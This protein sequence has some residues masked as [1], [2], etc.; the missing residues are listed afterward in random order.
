M[1]R[2]RTASPRTTIGMA[3]VFWLM[4]GFFATA[5]VDLPYQKPPKEILGLADATPPPQAMIDGQ[6]KYMALLTQPRFI[7]LEE[8]AQP[9]LKLAGLRINPR[10]HDRSRSRYTTGLA[11]QEVESGKAIPLT[12]LPEKLHLEYPRFSPGSAYFSF[13]QVRPEGMELWVIELASGRASRVTPP[14]LT[15]AIGF[16]YI[17]GPDE[18]SVICRTRPTTALFP[19]TTEL[20]AG[21]AIQEATGTKAAA[22]TYQ[23]LLRNKND[24]RKLEFYGTCAVTRYALD[25]AAAPWLPARLYRE[26]ELSPDGEYLLTTEVHPPYSYQFPGD[27]FP[28]AVRIY[29]RGGRMVKEMCDKP[30]QDKIPTAFD[31][32]EDGRRD[33]SWRD[34]QP[35]TLYW[36]EAADGG[37]PARE[38]M[39]RDRV[40]QLESPFAGE[41]RLVCA[42]KNRCRGIAWGSSAVA[43]VYD[44][45]WKT[46][47]MKIYRID[48]STTTS[49]PAILFDFSRED[50]YHQP[51]YFILKSDARGRD[52]LLSNRDGTKLYLDGEGYS[53]EGNRPF[54]DE[55]D[56]KTGRTKR[57]WQADGLKTYEDIIRVLDPDAG[58]LLTRIQAP[59]EYP[60]YYLR[61]IGSAAG[62][63]AV[64]AFPNPYQSF[65][66]VTKRQIHYKREDGL[67]LS[68]TLYLPPGYDAQKDGRLPMLMEAYPTEFKDKDAAGQVDDSPYRFVSFSWASPV[69]WA[70][71]GYAVLQD[72]KFPIVGQGQVEPNDTYIEQLVMDARAA[73]GAVDTLGVVDPKRVGV[74]GHSYG[75][76]MVANL[77]A[78]SDLF[79][80]G[81]ARSGAYNRSLTPFGF[82]AEERNYWQAQ[83]VYQKMSP[84]N[85]ADKIK[86]PLLLIHGDADNNPGT[87]TLQSERLFLA[88][89]GLG[90]TARLVL[91]PYESH[92]YAA[93]E[94]ILHMLW[95][96]DTWL[97]KY[98]KGPSGK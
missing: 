79:A 96:M 18:K 82:Q 81:I 11:I 64:T 67:D 84:F 54:L 24:E 62:P 98:V 3:L 66:S 78:H 85:Y 69:F 36:L 95:E 83:S 89:K 40:Y 65:A 49:E 29:D 94:N 30:L 52:R 13:I 73:I 55:F 63:K 10:T 86:A 20:P 5:Q 46:R 14:I 76:F 48:P 87:F 27:H 25:G 32:V 51:G 93:R 4:A 2:M 60:N 33:F 43:I 6:A 61:Q 21:P 28:Y 58:R 92:G 15:A 9:E 44:F 50:L 41:P 68:A 70:V 77:L 72:A 53:P 38:S 56:L 12:G 42:T 88:I 71:R 22:W 19:E 39:I 37:D 34:D 45:W 57:L 74:M 91:L 35:A 75:A 8:L 1:A 59:S 16:P 26:L 7:S 90:G 80:A 23:D 31:A 97:E 17:W 47:N